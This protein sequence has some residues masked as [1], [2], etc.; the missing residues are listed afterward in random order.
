MAAQ[1]F[2]L[3]DD[4]TIE[5]GD[6][7]IIESDQQHIEHIVTAAPGNFYEYPTLGVNSKQ[8]L[9]STETQAR[10]RQII[11]EEL[12]KDDFVVKDILLEKT[13]DS[14]IIEVDADRRKK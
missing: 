4:M 14:T 10:I 5:N 2:E 8:L 13:E 7:K 3:T 12:E 1:D 9:N 6:F 11:S